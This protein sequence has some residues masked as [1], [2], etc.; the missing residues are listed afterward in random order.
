MNAPLPAPTFALFDNNFDPADTRG[1]WLLTDLAEAVTCGPGDDWQACLRRLEAA[2]RQGAPV[3]IAARYELGYVIEPRLRPLLPADAE[4]LISA[5]I[6]RHSQWLDDVAC[7]AWLAAHAE[8]SAGGVGRLDALIQE[9]DYLARVERVRAYIAAGDCYQVNFTFPLAGETFGDPASL[10][11]ALRKAQPVRYGAFV[12]HPDGA[13]LSRS[14]E[15]FVERRGLTLSSEPMKGTAPRSCPPDALRD[16]EKDRAE[17]LMI[18][19]LIR[20]DMG[21]LAPPGG[22]R[23]DDLFRVEAYPTVWQMTSRISAEPVE[24]DLGEIF[25][26]L[27]PCGSITG[28]PRIRAMEIIRELESGPRGLYCG[29]LGWLRPGGDFRFSVPIRSLLM[30]AHRRVRLNVGSGVIHDSAPAAE[31][32]ECHLKSRFLTGLPKGLR[33]IETLRYEPGEAPFP[34]LPEH[35]ARLGESARALGFRFDEAAFLELLGGVRS[36]RALRVRVTL[37]QDGD[38]TLEQASLAQGLPADDPSV[39][40]SPLRTLSDDLLYRHKTTARALYDAELAR[41]TGLG[42]FDA[43]FLNEK[44]ELT[45]GARSNVFVDPGGDG[46]GMLLTPPLEAGLLNGVLRRRLLAEGRARETRL[47]LDELRNAQTVFVGN[48]L[49]GLLRVRLVTP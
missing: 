26:A 39:V 6:F 34:F 24:A 20:N 31:W 5:W 25:R 44:G 10:Y 9:S 12:V 37:G 30:D 3:A 17:N 23:V 29:A 2:A 4:P 11:R 45:E 47:G 13:I 15:L 21:R 48:S 32:A 42:H 38:F 35:R 40:L 14:P 49:R 46:E 18:V 22:V 7:D 28:A 16:S 1:A 27:F 19:D 41:V 8:I 36:G 43:L 33:L